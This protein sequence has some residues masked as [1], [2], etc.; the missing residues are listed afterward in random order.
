MEPLLPDIDSLIELATPTN[1]QIAPDGA[2][3]AY[4]INQPDW[5]ENQYINQIW[6]IANDPTAEPRQL[7]FTKKGSTAPCWSPNGRYL[8][9]ISQRE[10]DEHPQLY[11]LA[12]NGGEAERL[13][14]LETG[15]QNLQWSPDGQT[16]A[17]TALPPESA[18]EKARAEKYGD[19][20]EDNV[21]YKR[22]HLWLLM[23]A[24][25]KVRQLTAGDDLHIGDFQWHPDSQQ[26]AFSA[27]P[28]P[29]YDQIMQ[30]RIYLLDVVSLDHHPV[31]NPFS[32]TPHWSPD[33]SA[34]VYLQRTTGTGAFYKNAWLEIF[35][36]ADESRQRVAL[37]FDEDPNPLGW[38][39]LGIYFGALQR[40]TA[41][42]FRVPAA[43]GE[44]VQVT[45]DDLPGFVA[46][47][48][49][50]SQDY[51]RCGLV[52]TAVDTCAEVAATRFSYWEF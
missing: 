45:P 34:L 51:A 19:Y 31:T 38:A 39:D 26:L 16:I 6:L 14:E 3:I 52:Y 42:L 44:A 24:D 41:H 32:T 35:T 25:K 33:G 47:D 15:V 11:R 7:T 40:T 12:I 30:T 1:P 21:D 10:G 13:T 17:F 50:F 5:E 23:L 29:D 46:T 27:A 8:A 43:G 9:F 18:A 36:L 48:Y 2:A 49:S 22:S 28:S 4:V 37:S 20:T